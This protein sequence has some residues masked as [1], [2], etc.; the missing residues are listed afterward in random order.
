MVK[1]RDW[2]K[3]ED[4]DGWRVSLLDSMMV[5]SMVEILE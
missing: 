4:W 1:L 3:V 5:D 2:K